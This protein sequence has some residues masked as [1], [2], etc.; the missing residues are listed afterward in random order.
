[1]RRKIWFAVLCGV[2]FSLL[3]SSG[4]MA[5]VDKGDAPKAGADFDHAVK[6]DETG[7]YFIEGDLVEPDIIAFNN[8][9]YCGWYTFTPTET[10]D[11]TFYGKTIVS[12]YDKFTLRIFDKYEERIGGSEPG[13]INSEER[14][15]ALYTV[16]LQAQYPY[17]IRFAVCSDDA[18]SIKA[19]LAICS[20]SQHA[21]PGNPGEKCEICG[22][23]IQGLF[24]SQQPASTA[25]PTPK[26]TVKPTVPASKVMATDYF[27]GIEVAMQSTHYHNFNASNPNYANVWESIWIHVPAREE[28]IRLESVSWT[29]DVYGFDDTLDGSDDPFTHKSITTYTYGTSVNIADYGTTTNAWIGLPDNPSLAGDQTIVL[30]GMGWRV[31]IG[32]HLDY[33]GNYATGE[34]WNVY[35]TSISSQKMR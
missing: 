4:A 17:Y 14:N 19:D 8:A 35:A 12:K 30:T 2:L 31:I 27:K 18:P 25:K 15:E 28:D 32:V 21:L 24:Q 26:P 5:V 22:Q 29:D 10:G 23:T 1:M 34:G 16:P 7:Y 20:P 13:S 11:Y 6:I 9:G 33:L 3:L